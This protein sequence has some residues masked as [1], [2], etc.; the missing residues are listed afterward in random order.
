MNTNDPLP[1]G[2]WSFPD[3]DFPD[4]P[5]IEWI[6]SARRRIVGFH[7]RTVKE[8]HKRGAAPRWYE[9]ESATTIRIRLWPNGPERIQQFCLA[10]DQLMF[11]HPGYDDQE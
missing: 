9:P 11:I 7:L 8:P 4:Y 1:S 6:D 3:K 5:H 2:V 10:P